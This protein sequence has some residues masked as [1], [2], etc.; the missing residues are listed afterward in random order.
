M[1]PENPDPEEPENPEI[2]W[3]VDMDG[4]GLP[5]ALEKETGTDPE[6]ADTDGDGLSDY[7]EVF[8]I[9][10]DPLN[11]SSVQAGVSDA[12][13]DSDRDGI[14]NR[15]EL[16]KGL[17]PADADSD[18]DG[19]SDYDELYIYGSDPKDADSDGD[20]VRD[21]DEISLGLDPLNGATNGVPDG[22]CVIHQ[23]VGAD[24]EALAEINTSDSPYR[25]SMEVDA[26][27]YVEGNLDAGETPY[28]YTI[29]NDAILGNA[30][31]LEYQ[32][33]NVESVTIKFD[34]AEAY[35]ENMSGLY[36]QYS[37]V[38]QGICR[39]T[40]FCWVDEVNMMIPVR[41]QYDLA[42]HIVYAEVN[43]FG[44]YCLIDRE[45][46]YEQLGIIPEGMEELYQNGIQTYAATM[47][48][49]EEAGTADTGKESYA[50]INGES[51][52][53]YLYGGH[54]YAVYTG[55]AT[56]TEAEAYCESLGGH[57]AAI[58][59]QEEQN[60]IEEYVLTADIAPRYW[61]GGYSETY[62][63]DFQWVTGEEFDYTNW[64]EGE[65]NFSNERYI[66]IYGNY[67]DW[68]GYWNNHPNV[69]VTKSFI[70]EWEEEN[71][72]EN[73]IKV[74]S[75]LTW[76]ALPDDFGAVSIY[77]TQ[78]YDGDNLLDV[79]EIMFGHELY[80][81]ADENGEIELPTIGQVFDYVAEKNGIELP[82]EWGL[83][84]DLLQELF[85]AKVVLV[86]SDPTRIDTD[87][88]GILDNI[89]IRPIKYDDYAD[90]YIEFINAGYIDMNKMIQ[91][92]D[93]FT[94]CMTPL[95]KILSNMGYGEYA[96]D[97]LSITGNTPTSN[98][99]MSEVAADWYLYSVETDED[100]VFSLIKLR[101][102]T[103]YNT[104]PSVAVPFIELDIDQMQTYSDPDNL[105]LLDAEFDNIIYA[106]N[107][108][109]NYVLSSYFEQ[110]ESD[111][112]YVIPQ[113]Y[114]RLVI[115]NECIDQ[116]INNIYISENVSSRY[117]VNILEQYQ[118][119]NSDGN[120]EIYD[121]NGTDDKSDDYIIIADPYHPT[122]AEQECILAIR[123]GNPSFDSFAAE[124]VYHAKL[125]DNIFV[126]D[127]AVKADLSVGD[128]KPDEFIYKADYGT[129]VKSQIAVSGGGIPDS[130]ILKLD[131][132]TIFA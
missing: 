1:S 72:L 21:G 45:L 22:E 84:D 103:G 52:K 87:G 124:I 85:A 68:Y 80:G 46:W 100:T 37:E 122:L 41:T 48:S 16:D 26:T 76:T 11:P 49:E 106:N 81:E 42:N 2:D 129:Y 119:G 4:D 130:L 92:D 79:Q 15:E 118:V 64:R 86:L 43:E 35:R 113:I 110:P 70:C 9:G 98:H 77:S 25:L 36:A 3:S 112:L 13:A 128:K 73:D 67:N 18:Y 33:G 6:V 99:G 131:W 24:S 53:V 14:S 32:D 59:S 109:T 74:Y 78:D 90:K 55:P 44:T 93:G 8:I 47:D 54:M 116:N 61:I 50:L 31:E 60:F 82:E 62:P 29:Q 94:I 56:W 57:L 58:S 65:P 121:D 117:A 17:N 75:A 10:T 107:A 34:I 66:E 97:S 51:K 83:G 108:Q 40:V 38:N 120:P 96:F 101:D 115:Q 63:F 7:E 127:H 126:H 5:D 27:G 132:S 20:G 23:I 88:E 28:A 125:A 19:I 123:S 102:A 111:A 30:F 105:D 12:D 39:L 91:T 69:C 71:I 89:D 114:V 95:P 104:M